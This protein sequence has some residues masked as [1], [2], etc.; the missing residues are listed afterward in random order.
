MEKLR[1]AG[2]AMQKDFCPWANRW[3]Y[4]MKNPFC[5]IVVAAVTAG[6]C[7]F[8]L[9]PWLWVPTAALLAIA[10]GGLVLPKLAIRGVSL[11]LYFD[12]RRTEANQP[13]VVRLVAKNRWWVPVWGLSVIRG[14]SKTDS[15]DATEGVSL[16]RVPARSEVEYAWEFAPSRRG[17]YPSGPVTVETGF[18]F[19][20]I[21]ASRPAVVHGSLTVWPETV[22]LKGL[23]DA[24]ESYAEDQLSP[25]RAGHFGDVIGTRQFRDGDSLRRV[26]WAQSARRQTLIVT[27]RQAPQSSMV[28]VL[29]DL[30]KSAHDEV[31]EDVTE[32]LVS[33]AASICRSLHE[34]H[35][36]V[37]CQIGEKLFVA[38]EATHGFHAMMDEFAACD[39]DQESLRP[40]RNSAAFAI[41]VTT[42]AGALA[43]QGHQCVI[44]SEDEDPA[45]HSNWMSVAGWQ[46]LREQ[47]PDAWKEA[48][49]VR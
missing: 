26:H 49:H 13:V 47:F 20:L 2:S 32:C 17:V 22:S 7:A 34:Q 15:A 28:R 40:P 10:V 11:Q 16:A 45:R 31:D 30:T 3:V 37:E 39:A 18:P 8:C 9:N 19:G 41:V 36:R 21:R 4:W 27:E 33:T 43:N 23:P 29:V 44:L 1:Q 6:I 25:N 24:A 35:C 38:G 5:L 14:L 42:E 48:C 46:G 12:V